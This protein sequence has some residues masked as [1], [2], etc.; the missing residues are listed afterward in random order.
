VIAESTASRTDADSA[1]SRSGGA[2]INR[3]S[4]TP[5]PAASTIST[6]TRAI[7]AA[8]DVQAPTIYR[9][10][11]ELRGLLVEAASVGFASYLA[12]KA[13]Q[14]PSGDPVEDLRHGWDTHVAFGLDEPA[15][16]AL[17]YGDPRQG[18]RSAAVQQ[19]RAML[20][21][22]VQRIAETGRL[23]VGIDPSHSVSRDASASR[24][25]RARAET[26]SSNR[27]C[28]TPASSCTQQPVTRPSTQAVVPALPPA[29]K[30]WLQCG[31]R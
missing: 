21:A 27:T 22:I 10:F 24:A 4:T 7:T 6:A 5:A 20:R 11:G 3:W 31:P 2:V 9:Q 8:A 14:Q 26:R 29:S 12:G 28:T 16:Y 1:R 18:E 25:R 17:L 13:A 23:R 19:A 30:I 15:A